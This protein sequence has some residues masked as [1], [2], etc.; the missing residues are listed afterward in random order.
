MAQA[1]AIGSKTLNESISFN[2]DGNK[3]DCEKEVKLLGVTIDCQLKFNRLSI[4][5][6]FIIINK[7]EGSFLIFFNFSGIGLT[8]EMRNNWTIIKITHY[9]SKIYT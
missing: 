5:F 9:K 2:L 1:I 6:T 7:S 8:T 3:I 4:Y